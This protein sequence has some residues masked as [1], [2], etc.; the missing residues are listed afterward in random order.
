MALDNLSRR[1]FGKSSGYGTRTRLI[2]NPLAPYFC[3][4]VCSAR[5][6]IASEFPS[7]LSFMI[8]DGVLRISL[9]LPHLTHSTLRWHYIDRELFLLS[10]MKVFSP[11]V[12]DGLVMVSIRRTGIPPDLRTCS[13]PPI[14]MP[15]V[16]NSAYANTLRSG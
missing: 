7:L 5:L 6:T 3:F 16:A 12:I 2:I 15:L 14:A 1:L 4:P 9:S 11:S 13:P 8:R 10:P